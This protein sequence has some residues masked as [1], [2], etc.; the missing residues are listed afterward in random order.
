MQSV[1]DMARSLVLRTNQ[2][3]LRQQMDKLAVEVATG[4]AKDS[5]KSRSRFIIA[6]RLA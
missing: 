4:F 5:A 6:R 2:V 1:G 3:Q